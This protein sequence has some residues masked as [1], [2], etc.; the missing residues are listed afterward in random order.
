LPAPANVLLPWQ[1]AAVVAVH[2]PLVAQ[3]AP[4]IEEDWQNVVDEHA[5]P[6][7]PVPVPWNVALPVQPEAVVAL[8]AP[9]AEQHAPKLE[10]QK[11]A[12]VQVVREVAESYPIPTPAKTLGPRQPLAVWTVHPPVVEQHA[13]R[14]VFCWQ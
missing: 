11:V 2:E 7:T 9:A 8:H 4:R 6:L 3:H 12:G 14:M 5:V 1:P 13:P 10:L